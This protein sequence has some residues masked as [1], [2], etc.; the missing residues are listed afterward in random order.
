MGIINAK[1][2][3]KEKEKR[4]Y[5][6][7]L[8]DPLKLRKYPKKYKPICGVYF[9][10]HNERLVYIGKSLNIQTRISNHITENVK[11]FTSFSFVKN[12]PRNISAL[13]EAYIEAYKPKY[14]IICNDEFS[15][16][17]EELEKEKSLGV[18]YLAKKESEVLKLSKS[19]RKKRKLSKSGKSFKI[20]PK[21]KHRM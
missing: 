12:S 9:L 5:K 1:K 3:H 18:D 14:N 17:K 19:E 13:E 6:I 10:F 20:I 15:D 7:S 21:A 8:R 11:L 4:K 2:E 16:Y